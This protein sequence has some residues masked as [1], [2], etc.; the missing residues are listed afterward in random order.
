MKTR[1]FYF[2]LPSELIAQKPSDRRGGSRL[3][4]FNRQ[5]AETT[6]SFIEHLHS[7]LRSGTVV[8]LNDTRVRKTRLYG[9]GKE[10]GIRS[11]FLL[12]EEISPAVWTSMVKRAKRKKIGKQF[13]FPG[14]VTAT[15][16]GDVVSASGLLK[17]LH[18]DRLLT[19]SYFQKYGHVPLPPYIKRNATSED[20]E[21][22][23][24][25]FSRAPGSIAAPTAGLHF[26]KE[27]LSDLEEH[28]LIL[29]CI[30][31]HVGIGT[32]LPIKS[33]TVEEHRMHCERF[34]IS[35]Q[36]AE[37]VEDAKRS[38]RDVLAVGTTVVRALESAWNG[39]KLVPGERTTEMF[40]YPGYNF[41]V[42]D[43]LLTN[44]HTPES[45]LLLLVAAFA[46]RTRI[47]NLYREAIKK[48]YLFYTYGDAMLIQ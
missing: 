12:V 23:Q 41:R 42:V 10:T 11:E 14:N 5:T 15:I 17:I 16:V 19:E 28:G 36:T 4:V 39:K 8:V 32:F 45:T 3:L 30:T 33:E 43:R 20:A 29:T 34:S 18:F 21:R 2:D 6:D 35:P 1:D 48:D 9:I 7:H 27:N 46:S 40:I 26:T 13:L 24:T 22:Y 38:D 25:V 44:F 47:L 37:L 31:L